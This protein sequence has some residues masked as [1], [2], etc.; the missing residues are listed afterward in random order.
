MQPPPYWKFLLEQQA[1]S[2]VGNLVA[3]KLAYRTRWATR[4]GPTG[5][6][7]YVAINVWA[8]P[9]RVPNR[10]SPSDR[11][12]GLHALRR[13]EAAGGLQRSADDRRRQGGVPGQLA[14]ATSSGEGSRGPGLGRIAPARDERRW[15][16]RHR[17]V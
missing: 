4:A 16:D 11:A 6:L 15:A 10:G 13:S 17:L 5:L 12:Q 9:G 3:P 1:M 2:F 14:G 8:D 7:I